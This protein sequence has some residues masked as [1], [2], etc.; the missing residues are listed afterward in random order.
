MG[1]FVR[2]SLAPADC[3]PERKPKVSMYQLLAR[4]SVWLRVPAFAATSEEPTRRESE[5]ERPAPCWSGSGSGRRAFASDVHGGGECRARAVRLPRDD[6]GSVSV[7]AVPV[8]ELGVL[9]SEPGHRDAAGLRDVPPSPGRPP[10][11]PETR[12]AVR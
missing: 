3:G 10:S 7:R 12:A 9:F 11:E 4:S 8:A 6:P 5:V 2:F 1:V